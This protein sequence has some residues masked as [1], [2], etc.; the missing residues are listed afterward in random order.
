MDQPAQL[1]AASRT[2]VPVTSHSVGSSLPGLAQSSQH[3]SRASRA[4]ARQRLDS[5]APRPSATLRS[6]PALRRRSWGD[7]LSYG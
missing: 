2:A 6:A 1:S 5:G 4:C 3:P 7:G